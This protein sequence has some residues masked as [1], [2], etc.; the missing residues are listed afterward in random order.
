MVGKAANTKAEGDLLSSTR[1]G[2]KTR[3]SIATSR[4]FNR[5]ILNSFKAGAVIEVP[6]NPGTFK[7][8]KVEEKTKMLTIKM[9][10]AEIELPW[11]FL[12]P[13][14]NHHLLRTSRNAD[15]KAKAA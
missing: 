13:R 6:G 11:S 2:Q 3:V 8:L 4:I 10:R 12:A 14:R 9:G 15:T 7:V 1:M 5:K